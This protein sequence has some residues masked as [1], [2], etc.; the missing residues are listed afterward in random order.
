MWTRR[1]GQ[2]FVLGLLLA[3]AMF[4]LGT[5]AQV[6]GWQN[7]VASWVITGLACVIGLLTIWL[8]YMWSKQWGEVKP[9]TVG[10]VAGGRSVETQTR[11]YEWEATVLVQNTD[12]ERSVLTKEIYLVE[13]R[14]IHRCY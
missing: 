14:S 7:L 1:Q 9:L 11:L 2:Q 8:A 13:R 3:I 10:R 5:A 6:G 4:A 12:D